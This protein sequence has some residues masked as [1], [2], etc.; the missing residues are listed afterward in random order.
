MKKLLLTGAI[1]LASTPMLISAADTGS[2][3]MPGSDRDSH[4][5]IGSAGYVWSES[6]QKCI[7]PWE[8]TDATMHGTGT[9]PHPKIMTGSEAEL[10]AIHIAISQLSETDRAELMKTIKTYVES[11]G[12]KI[13]TPDQMK[14]MKEENKADRKEVK[15]EIRKDK[16]TAQEAAKQKREDMRK[17]MQERKAGLAQQ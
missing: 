1:L 17:R 13:P 6:A 8:Q 7:R 12:V 15:Q 2:T 14:N 9:T 10:K 11:K 4:G 5:C 16:K 3:M